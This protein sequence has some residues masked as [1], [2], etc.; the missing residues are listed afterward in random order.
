MG[1]LRIHHYWT[2]NVRGQRFRKTIHFTLLSTATTATFDCCFVNPVSMVTIVPYNYMVQATNCDMQKD[3]LQCFM[4]WHNG[5]G[6][7]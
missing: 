5:F 1:M 4:H 2:T 3:S 6:D 7:R